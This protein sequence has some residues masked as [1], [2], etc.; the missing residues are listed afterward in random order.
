MRVPEKPLVNG[1]RDY[2]DR[3]VKEVLRLYP[4]AWII[5]RE[6]L[7]DVTL[8]DGHRIPSKMTIFLAPLLLHRRADY[9]P[10]PDTFDPDRWLGADPPPFAYVPFGAGARRCIGEE[11]RPQRSGDRTDRSLTA[12]QLC[13][14]TGS[15]SAG[16]AVGYAAPGRPSDAACKL[17]ARRADRR[18]RLS[19][20]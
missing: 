7:R 6:S 10:D 3:V 1:N 13:A 9:F 14:G 16:R 18:K 5:G 17:A 19:Y 4:P 15:T 12:I 11:F 20:G 8:S 2:I